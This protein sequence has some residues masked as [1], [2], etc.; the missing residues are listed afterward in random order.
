M[1][2]IIFLI[3]VYNDW[4]SLIKLLNEIN[5][6]I[7]DIKKFEFDCI[8]VND[9]SNITQPN[10]SKPSNIKS[11]KLLNMKKNK[12]HARCNAFG[13]R[14]I[15]K[16]LFFDNVI[17]MDGDGEDRP[18]EILELIGQIEK[19][20]NISVVAKRIRRSEGS[21]FKLM[22]EAHKMITR[23]FTGKKI[24][25]GNYCCLTRK[26]VNLLS[27]KGSLWS[28]FSGS[29]KKHIL[30]L[31]EINSERG[32]RYFGPSKMSLLSLILHSFSI[33]AVFKIQV[34]FR[35]I[36]IFVLLSYLEI[37]IGIFA[38][39]SQILLIFFNL[40]ILAVSLREKKEDLF[41]SQENLNTVKEIT[42]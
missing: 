31:N 16:N 17:L 22:Y 33:I 14:F 35:S 26:D 21:L 24:Q 2:K 12:G 19:D 30:K 10:I 23:I 38:T 6:I 29:V 1:K 3:P 5:S 13:L 27:D 15:N 41:N 28:S 32:K 40:I 20:K 37:Y 11:L 18:I 34:F 7:N 39:I 36:L 4:E 9:A 25:F 8:I 42:H